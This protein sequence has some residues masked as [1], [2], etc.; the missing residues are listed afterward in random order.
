MIIIRL[1][2]ALD[3]ALILCRINSHSWLTVHERKVC[4]CI[5]LAMVRKP[6]VRGQFIVPYLQCHDVL[7]TDYCQR[8]RSPCPP[9]AL[10][11]ENMVMR[12]RLQHEPIT[13]TLARP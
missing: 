8:F 2:F 1:R 6:Y 5:F 12:N 4:Q 3:D 7:V 11:T 9:S 13:I 10:S